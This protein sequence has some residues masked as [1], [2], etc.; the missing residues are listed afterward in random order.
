M[1]YKAL[2]RRFRPQIFEDVIGQ[3]SI[4]TTLKNQIKSSNISHAYLFSGTRGTGKTSTA[5]IFARGVN[6][7]NPQNYNPCNECEVCK[8][9]LTENIMDVIEI[10]AASNNGVDHIRELRE[11]VKYP[12]SKGRYKVYIIDEVHMLSSGAFNALLKTLEEPPN[13]VI[14]ILATTDPQKLPATILSRCQR[15]DFKAVTTQDML[16]RLKDICDALGVETEDKALRMIAINAGGALR[17]ALSILEQCISFTDGKLTEEEVIDTLGIVN[18]EILFALVEAIAEKNT[19]KAISL[20]QTVVGEGKDIQ[21]LIKDLIHY[22]RNLMM[23]K[24]EVQLEELLSMSN[25]VL[26][27]LKQQSKRFKTKDITEAIYTLSDIEVKAKYAAH[28]RIL[29]EVGIVALCQEEEEISTERLVERIHRLEKI[30]ASPPPRNI[31]EKS[32]E[33]NISK[34]K[35]DIALVDEKEEML[36]VVPQEEYASEASKAEEIEGDLVNPPDFSTIEGQWQEVKDAIKRDKKAQVEAILKEGEL[37][38]IKGHT[39]IISFKDGYG[40]HRETL[41]K[42]KNKEY[43]ASVIEKVTG[44]KLKLSF[45]MAYEATEKEKNSEEDIFV[46]KLKKSVPEGLLE[47][48][49]E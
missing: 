38:T 19:S 43:I 45:I 5:K 21:Q 18:Y 34:K 10:D 40:F 30:V 1:A 12:P 25:E 20:V 3:S 16:K 24:M 32:I 15:F 37:E 44:Q 46:E 8:G 39:L 31:Y 6:C 11:N 35:Q 22:F 2:Y 4:T 41:D 48:F 47:V 23:A 9:I 36:S 42:E 29:L 26:D 28:P 33:S 13:H 14:F 27:Q 7:L 17:D 49:D